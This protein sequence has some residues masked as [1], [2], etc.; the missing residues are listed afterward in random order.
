MEKRG[1]AIFLM[2]LCTFFTSIAQVF[3]KL[4]AIRLPEI[5]TNYPILIG[6]ILYGI[7]A[8][9]LITALKLDEVTILYPILAT[10]YV[11]VSFLAWGIFAESINIFKWIGIAFIIAGISVIAFGNDSGG[12]VEYTEGV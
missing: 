2:V 7:G 8:I 6:L 11:W 4:G 3:Y 12:V 9:I 5:F 10:S 1:L